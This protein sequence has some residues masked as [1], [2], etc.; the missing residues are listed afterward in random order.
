MLC[1]IIPMLLFYNNAPIMPVRS[2]PRQR[3][4]VPTST[5]QCTDLAGF[6]GQP[7]LK[8]WPLRHASPLKPL[9]TDLPNPSAGHVPLYLHPL[10]PIYSPSRCSATKYTPTSVHKPAAAKISRLITTQTSI[11]ENWTRYHHLLLL[12]RLFFFF[13]HVLF[14]SLAP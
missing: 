5:R 13:F 11:P 14:Q 1:Y 6:S 4:A 12:L 9:A 7:A 8:D 2:S 10:Y 3:Q